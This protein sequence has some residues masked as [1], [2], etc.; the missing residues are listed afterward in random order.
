[1]DFISSISFPNEPLIS[2][3]F[4]GHFLTIFVITFWWVWCCFAVAPTQKWWQKWPRTVQLIRGSFR[5]KKS[6]V[7]KQ[8]LKVKFFSAV[9]W[10]K[11]I[12]KMI[13]Q[14]WPVLK[15]V[16]QSNL[17]LWQKPVNKFCGFS[18]WTWQPVRFFWIK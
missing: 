14:L 8:V 2:W 16:P 3:T 18:N 11:W 1:M 12:S 15:I 13:L 9:E 4:L 10:Q 5:L 7:Q 6:Y 17:R